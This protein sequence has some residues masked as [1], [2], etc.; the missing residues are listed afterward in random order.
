VQDVYFLSK[1][2]TGIPQV[3]KGLP[4]LGR[5]GKADLAQMIDQQLRAY[6]REFKELK[7]HLFD[8]VLELIAYCERTLSKPGGHLLLA[9]RS[10]V[11]RRTTVQLISHMLNKE[12]FTP[13]ISREYS[14]KEFKR[15][16]KV[17][18]QKAGVEAE[19]V[20]FYIEDHHLISSEILEYLN[21]LISAGEAP[22]L[23]AP[24][25]LEPICA[26][27]HDELRNQYECRTPFELFVRRVQQNLSIVVSLDNSHPQFLANCAS[28]P[29]LYTKCSILW[30][31]G[32]SRDAMN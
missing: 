19:K 6:E 9:G 22:G 17:V 16:L 30:H 24:E 25:E 5:V 18:M 7:V 15:D 28:N 32:W 26:G 20:T 27:L 2:G 29:A 21:S 31:E 3:V 14:M 13:S 1:M 23:Y 4:G 12:F 10:G 8:E 11:G